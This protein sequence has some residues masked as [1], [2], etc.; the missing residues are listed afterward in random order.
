MFAFSPLR[1]PEQL[2]S[3]SG[4]AD[5]HGAPVDTL[6]AARLREQA[7]RL[8]PP[9]AV[10]APTTRIPPQACAPREPSQSRS[11]ARCVRLARSS[12]AVAPSSQAAQ[13][14]SANAGRASRGGL[15]FRGFLVPA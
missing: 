2:D 1:R 13:G 10:Q 15:L 8:G 4:E 11:E 7:R 12:C 6:S 14:H 3:M 5:E 9:M